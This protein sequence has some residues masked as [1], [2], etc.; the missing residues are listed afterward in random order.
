MSV[1]LHLICGSVAKH[2]E[3]VNT[4]FSY[5]WW[6]VGFFWVSSGGQHLTQNAPRLYWLCITFLAFDVFFVV[7]F[8]AVAC[9]VGIA[10]CC[11]LPCIIA[12]LWWGNGGGG[13]GVW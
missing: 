4:M 3:S 9:V 6:I 13:G 8:V 11:C 1:V 10:V 7:I 2:L 12:I 5:I